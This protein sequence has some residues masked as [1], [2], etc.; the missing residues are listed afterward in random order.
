MMGYTGNMTNTAK[1]LGEVGRG[2]PDVRPASS[3][4]QAL[5]EL[6]S[7]VSAAE[8]GMERLADKL[9]PVL[10]LRET[11]VDSCGNPSP[12]PNCELEERILQLAHRLDSLAERMNS[13]TYQLC[14]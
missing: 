12:G 8:V 6:A 14:V 3:M 4:E 7:K 10:S 13:T 11:G 9:R 5:D 2:A 1:M